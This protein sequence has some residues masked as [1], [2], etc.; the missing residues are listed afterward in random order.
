MEP[1]VATL[2]AKR[3]PQWVRNHFNQTL[4]THQSLF[5]LIG[6]S[7]SGVAML[8]TMP[9][10]VRYLAET[11]GKGDHPATKL[12][13]EDAEKRAELAKQELSEDFPVLHALAVVQT[14][15]MT[16]NLIKGL[17]THWII[18]HKD[19]YALPAIHKLRI[20]LGEFVNQSEIEQ[21]EYVVELLEQDLGSTFKGGVQRFESMLQ[22]F[23]LSGPVPD[24]CSKVM[25]ELQ[26]VRNSIAHR[27]G[28]V[29]RR[30]RDACP[31]LAMPTGTRLRV[32]RVMLAGYASAAIEYLLM[33][34]Y[35]VG[36]TYGVDRPPSSERPT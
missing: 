20:R 24:E 16:E 10:V 36:D 6:I 28:I 32:S 29:D 8:V 14:W 26:H 17:L 35:R 19:S 21:A 7:R 4:D 13:I 18:N 34:L 33:V 22:P 23:S 25:F 2:P 30:L 12:Q 15:S 11:D 27:N 5:D 1:L 3:V 31:W 9:K